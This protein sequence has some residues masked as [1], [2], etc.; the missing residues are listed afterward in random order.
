MS[1]VSGNEAADHDEDEINDEEEEIVL[2][3]VKNGLKTC[4]RPTWW[5]KPNLKDSRSAEVI[6][7]VMVLAPVMALACVSGAIGY[8][9]YGFFKVCRNIIISYPNTLALSIFIPSSFNL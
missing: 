5:N 9:T 7:H 1:E 2:K 6:E 4:H 3:P 8:T